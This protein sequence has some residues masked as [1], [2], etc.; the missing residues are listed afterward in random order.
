MEDFWGGSW[1]GW[2]AWLLGWVD[3]GLVGS[4]VY[5]ISTAGG[6]LIGQVLEDSGAGGCGSSQF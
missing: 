3:F 2:L 5:R 6:R 4:L 1:L